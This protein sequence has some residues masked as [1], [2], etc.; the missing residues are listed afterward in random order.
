VS[1][2]RYEARIA[3]GLSCE[4]VWSPGRMDCYWSTAAPVK[5]TGKALRAY[6]SARA[7]F[8][9]RVA[10]IEDLRVTLVDPGDAHP[11]QNIAPVAGGRA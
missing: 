3:A 4:F 5:L 1:V 7:E 8:L 9:Q 11:V 2:V 10:T 6:R